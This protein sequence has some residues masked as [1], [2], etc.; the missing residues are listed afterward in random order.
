M[1]KI[2]KVYDVETAKSCF[3][4]WFQEGK[5]KDETCIDIPEKQKIF[6]RIIYQR[7]QDELPRGFSDLEIQIDNVKISG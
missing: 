1:E 4:V 6:Y 7:R 3:I 2:I 5:N